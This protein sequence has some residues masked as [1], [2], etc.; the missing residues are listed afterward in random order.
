MKIAIPFHDGY[1]NEHFGHSENYA[2]YTISP[3][4]S[5]INRTVI[6]GEEGCGCKSDIAQTLSDMG[7]SLMLA[8][9]MGQG[10]VNVLNG[11]GISVLRGC[12][13]DI[14]DVVRLWLSG[15]L[16]DSGDS[17]REHEHGCHSNG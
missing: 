1:V 3:E 11:A 7:V 12:S 10:A 17:C 15:S 5:I 2:V 13:G 9:N 6:K 16:T 14:G 8:G 4:N